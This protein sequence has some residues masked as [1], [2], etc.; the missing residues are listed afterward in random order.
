M[1]ETQGILWLMGILLEDFLTVIT[2]IASN[3]LIFLHNKT[4]ENLY[5]KH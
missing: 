5:A 3:L 1:E 2:P 4:N